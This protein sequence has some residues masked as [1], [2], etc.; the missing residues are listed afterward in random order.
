MVGLDGGWLCGRMRDG[1]GAWLGR[2]IAGGS[3]VG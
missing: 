1:C 3:V 2:W